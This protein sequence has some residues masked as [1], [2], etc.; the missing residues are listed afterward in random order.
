MTAGAWRGQP[1]VR[2]LEASLVGRVLAALFRVGLKDR[3]L[4][5]AGQAFMALVPMVV[6]LATVASSSGAQAVGTWLVEEYG[7]TGSSEAAVVSLFSRPPE[8]SSGLGVLGFL[9]LL[10]SVNSFARL[11]QRTYELAWGLP[12]LGGRRAVKG[13]AGSVMLLLTLGGMAYLSGLLD[14]GHPLTVVTLKAA[15]AVPAWW[16]TT[17]LLLG[18][19]VSWQLLLP[20]AV[21][22]AIGHVL[23][24]L[25]SSLWMP[26]LIERNADR[27]GV[28]GVAVALISWLLVLAFLVVTSAVVQ[29]QIGPALRPSRP[30]RITGPRVRWF[31]TFGRVALRRDRGP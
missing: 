31:G 3:A 19:R 28:I 20:G 27:Y 7:L 13:L 9:V 2:A 5:L 8:A 22:T 10:L 16:C 11:V 30:R 6:V 24:S 21:V 12:A 26:Y 4:S 14:A 1:W 25:G 23:T 15:V 18:G 29:A 17:Y